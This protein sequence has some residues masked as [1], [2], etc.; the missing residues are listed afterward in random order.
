MPIDFFSLLQQMPVIAIL[1]GITPEEVIQVA[2]VL[3]SNGIKI[4]EVP[5]NSPRPC[6]SIKR[7]QDKF[8]DRCVCGAGTVINEAQVEQVFNTGAQLVVSPNTNRDVIRKAIDLGMMPVPG[9]STPTEAFA[10]IE[11]GAR[12]L[13]LF[14]AASIGPDFLKALSVVIPDGVHIIATGGTRADT[15]QQWLAAGAA[16]LGVGSDLYQPGVSDADLARRA[17]QFSKAFKG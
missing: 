6:E 5:L 7:L 15:M 11:A 17:A 8:G 9:F 12:V 4:I 13:K 16:G 1:R 3:Y 14:P 10:A 2:D